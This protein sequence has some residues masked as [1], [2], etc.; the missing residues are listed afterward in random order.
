MTEA[1]SLQPEPFYLLNVLDQPSNHADIVWAIE[2]NNS[3]ITIVVYGL[4]EAAVSGSV[5]EIIKKADLCGG[6]I[7]I[8]A[9]PEG[10]MFKQCARW[11]LRLITELVYTEAYPR[12]IF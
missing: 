1:I 12:N 8:D 9:T 2:R 4:K 5:K 11:E 3:K 7:I 10:S 6:V